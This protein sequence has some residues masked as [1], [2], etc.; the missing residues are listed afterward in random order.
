[1]ECRSPCLRLRHA[2]IN[3]RARRRESAPSLLP[4]RPPGVSWLPL[5][6]QVRLGIS[7]LNMGAGEGCGPTAPH[8]LRPTD[9]RPLCSRALTLC[10]DQRFPGKGVG[11]R[12]VAGVA[13]AACPPSTAKA[14]R[15][16]LGGCTLPGHH[17]N[18]CRFVGPTQAASHATHEGTPRTGPSSLM[19]DRFPELAGPD[20]QESVSEQLPKHSFSSRHLGDGSRSGFARGG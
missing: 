15:L 3:I 5:E 4:S 19:E 20:T 6:V 18:I 7:R 17:G 11:G 13:A 2:P 16:L 1:M 8:E 12:H 10:C 9:P 14:A